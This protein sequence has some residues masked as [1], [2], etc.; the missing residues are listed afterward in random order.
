VGLSA[1]E[2]VALVRAASRAADLT[3][4]DD[5]IYW[6]RPITDDRYL[7]TSPPSLSGSAR[8]DQTSSLA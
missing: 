8:D 3:R 7:V 6:G 2:T 4:L 1:E 5:P